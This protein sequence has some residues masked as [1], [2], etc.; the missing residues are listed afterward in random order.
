MMR[1]HVC[2]VLGGAGPRQGERGA[3]FSFYSENDGRPLICFQLK[4]VRLDIAFSKDPPGCGV[5]DE[6]V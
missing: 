3:D 4:G 5:E 2:L 1:P 6:P